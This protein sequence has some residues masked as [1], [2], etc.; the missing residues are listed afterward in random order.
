MILEL[1]ITKKWWNNSTRKSQKN[2][3]FTYSRAR[4]T[5]LIMS[6]F[7]HGDQPAP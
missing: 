4:L 5:F 1:W 3:G 2:G 6:H 7:G